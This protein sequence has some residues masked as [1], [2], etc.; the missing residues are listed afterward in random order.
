MGEQVTA[1]AIYTRISQDQDGTGLG[2][3]RQRI[4]CQGLADRLG[5]PVSEVYADNDISA[6]SGKKRP[7]YRRLVEDIRAGR[8][9][10]VVIYHMDR[11]TRRPIELEEF[12]SVCQAAEMQ[13]EFVTGDA[14]LTTGDGLMMLRVMAAFAAGESDAKSRRL[15]RKNLELAEKG[16]PSMGGTNRP[17]GYQVDRVTVD[18]FEAGVI[19]DL[20]A[21]YLAG[22]SWRSL[23]D[24]TQREGIKTPTGR[25][26]AS[27]GLRTMLLSARL[28]GLRAHG[29]Q[30]VGPAVWEAIITPEQR[31]AMLARVQAG[32][33]TGRRTPRS[34]LLSGMLRCHK[35]GG[36]LFAAARQERRRYVCMSGPDHGGCGGT[37][38]AAGPVEE[39]V[40]RGV[41]GRLAS[42]ALF[43]AIAGR[44]RA[45]IDA[46]KIAAE[47]NQDAAQLQELAE[48]YASREITAPEW[49]KAREVI[50]Q[51]INT[52]RR[53]LAQA[54]RVDALD[55][56]D[57]NRSQDLEAQF[58]GLDL[59]RQTQIVAAVM[60]HAVIGPGRPGARSVDH[61]RVTAVWRL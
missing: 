53:Q 36:K 33:A 49:R 40:S 32:K 45:T 58:A 16:L 46:D 20:V 10:A 17:F 3:E 47:V 51:R 30:I 60:D 44:A 34:Y 61:N 41:L 13:V 23:A 28:A 42:P 31:D 56:L 1:A 27:T 50:E 48:M 8:R 59:S 54:A 19:R 5:W 52:G 18:E 14:D 43:D 57:L 7:A 2:V 9:D 11:L 21:R 4:D 55:F 22:E 26:W 15:K 35:C 39:L 37:M 38:I 12:V 29:G 24:W 25:D 6:H